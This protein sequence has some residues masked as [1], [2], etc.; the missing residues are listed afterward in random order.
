MKVNEI[1]VVFP[2][3]INIPDECQPVAE[4]QYVQ[5]D[6]QYIDN[7]RSNCVTRWGLHHASNSKYLVLRRKWQAPERLRGSG[8]W[9]W[10]RNGD[11]F[12]S[13]A[14]PFVRDG[15]VLLTL[16]TPYALITEIHAA[17]G[18]TQDAMPDWSNT[19]PAERK[20]RL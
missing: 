15:K 4:F 14:E 3:G 7:T 9:L 12:L 19:P 16:D 18:L 6:D 1:R 10:E 20:V 11:I 13:L 5:P 2:D 8:L 17:L